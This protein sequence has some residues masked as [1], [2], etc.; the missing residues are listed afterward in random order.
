MKIT[1]TLE[2]GITN[3]RVNAK[4][5]LGGKEDLEKSVVSFDMEYTL[6]ETG[7]S[8]MIPITVEVQGAEHGVKLKPNIKIQ[9]MSVD[10]KDIS[11]EKVEQSFENINSVTTSGKVNVKARITDSYVGTG[12]TKLW[13]SGYNLDAGKDDRSQIFP[14][15]LDFYINN[16]PNR[17]DLRGATFPS[18]KINYHFDFSGKVTWDTMGLGEEKLDFEGKDTPIKNI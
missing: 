17:G 11:N 10:G 12:V 15:T 4:F 5:S 2:N 14:V 18:G 6:K 9:V 13:Y 8:L 1:G 7:N 16:L 3:K